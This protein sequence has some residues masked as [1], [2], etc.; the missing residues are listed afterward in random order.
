MNKISFK[1]EKLIP[2]RP[3]RNVCIPSSLF[4][5]FIFFRL[6][7][8]TSFAFTQSMAS[9]ILFPPSPTRLCNLKPTLLLP[10]LS[11]LILQSHPLIPLSSSSLH[12]RSTLRTRTLSKTI[13][14]PQAY[15]TGPAS[16]P[17]FSDSDPKFD[18][19]N[20]WPE[21]VQP[22][23]VVSWRLLW[24]L[25]MKHKLRLALS[26]LSLICCTTCTLSMPLF[27]GNERE[28]YLM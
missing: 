20:P 1:R 9:S 4:S 25:L 28:L 10:S 22:P 21:K 17:I 15:V 23:S 6:P 26:A 2:C 27:S 24:M 5:I 8:C 13:T 16:D 7:H 3:I 19:S 12:F 18:G 11:P 14:T